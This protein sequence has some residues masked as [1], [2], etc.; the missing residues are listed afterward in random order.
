MA[1]AFFGFFCLCI[2]GLGSTQTSVVTTTMSGDKESSTEPSSVYGDIAYYMFQ[3]MDMQITRNNLV[4]ITEYEAT[5][6]AYDLNKD[7]YFTV[8]EARNLLE[9]N[10]MSSSPEAE[11]IFGN[12]SLTDRAE[13]GFRFTSYD[14]NNDNI[15]NL[16]E[17]DTGYRRNFDW[18]R[19]Q[20]MNKT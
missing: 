6:K 12:I 20:I 17:F 19:N 13:L 8:E 16:T 4:T 15:L 3:V 1:W 18:T 14:A 7:G 10:L 2:I 9:D 11:F 5:W